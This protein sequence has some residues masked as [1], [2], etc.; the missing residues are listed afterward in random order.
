MLVPVNLFS[1]Y[2]ANK[3]AVNES[4]I[5]VQAPTTGKCLPTFYL[6]NK[7]FMIIFINYL[8]SI[9]LDYPNKRRSST[10]LLST[11]GL[12]WDYQEFP[13]LEEELRKHVRGLYDV[14]KENKRNKS[15]IPM[16]FMVSGA[17]C[18]KS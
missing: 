10:P 12:S 9:F 13:K 16:F 14:F 11:S 8:V 18:G 7:K 5:I 4:L 1:Y 6:S 3:E 2:F 17:R 15:T